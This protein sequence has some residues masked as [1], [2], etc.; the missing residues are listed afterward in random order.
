MVTKTM[1]RDFSD[2]PVPPGELLAEELEERGMSQKE[3]AERT[4]RPEQS[5]SEIIHGKKAITHDT[6][7]ELEKVLGVSAAFWVSLEA[8]FRLTKARLRELTELDKQE[9]WLGEFPVREM[10]SRHLI[11][12]SYDKREVLTAILKFF[13]VASFTVLQQ[14]Q[15]AILD[16]RITPGSK[17]SPGALWVWLRVGEIEA[18]KTTTSPYDEGRF[19]NA[20]KEIRPLMAKEPKEFIPRMAELCA[21]AGVAFVVVKEFPKSGASGVSRWLSPDKALIQL[22]TKRRYADMFWFSFY[23]EAKHVLE[24]QRKRTFVNGI[25]GGLDVEAEGA[26]DRFAQEQLIPTKDW[27][28]FVATRAWSRPAVQSFADRIGVPPEIIVGRLQHQGLIPLDYLNNL[29]RRFVWSDD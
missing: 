19:I 8:S 2:L 10:R 20:L 11:P 5:I 16:Y 22:S 15:E 17:V 27:D 3:L 29:R 21:D 14:R 23:H 9:D 18:Q 7:L 6:A 13:E 28:A 25:D 12:K 1:D 4:G 26:A 24:R